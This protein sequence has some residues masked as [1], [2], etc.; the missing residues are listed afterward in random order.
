MAELVSCDM[1][2]N[3]AK[4]C[5][6]GWYSVTTRECEGGRNYW[7]KPHNYDLCPSCMEKLK[8]FIE[9]GVCNNG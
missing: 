1:C 9:T 4:P 3:T 6:H 8:A 5:T 2:H 7:S